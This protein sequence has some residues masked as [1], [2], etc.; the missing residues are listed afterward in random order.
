MKILAIA[1]RPPKERIKLILENNP[2]NMICTLGDLEQNYLYDIELVTSIPKLGVYG[3]H[4]SGTYIETLG[5]TNMH[6]KTLEFGGLVFGGFEGC[7]RYKNDPNAKMYTQEEAYE[8][9][10]DFPY[11]DVM[12]SH[13]PPFG[14]NDEPE[15]VAHQG[16]KAL[17]DYL[18]LKKP[19]YLLHGHTYP[20]SQNMMT[21]YGETHIIYIHEDMVLD[22]KK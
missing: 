17:T 16:F 12:L 19:K 2:I 5:I 21:K 13:C 20:T 15:E 18:L 6:L 22:I 4:D 7:V 3:N 9:L 10:K 14:V 8:M 1:D 11:V